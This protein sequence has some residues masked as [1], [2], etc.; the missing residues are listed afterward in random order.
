MMAS[1]TRSDRGLAMTIEVAILAPALVLL[2]AVVIGGGRYWYAHHTVEKVSA[3]AARAATVQRTASDARA[4]ARSVAQAETERAG[5][6]C[7]EHFVTIDTSGYGA[8]VGERATVRVTVACVVRYSELL[9]PG[10]P[11]VATVK[12]TSSSVLDSYRWRSP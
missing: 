5:L 11:G 8:P 12:H 9:I 1:Q 4:A 7:L 6:A 2:L 3:S 10:W